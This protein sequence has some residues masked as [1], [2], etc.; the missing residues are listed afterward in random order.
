MYRENF[1]L[2][3]ITYGPLVFIP[4]LIG[5]VLF[6]SIQIHNASFKEN[7]QKI[8]K[9]L[10]K[11]EK[12]AITK[13]VQ[14]ISKFIT[15]KKSVLKQELKQKVRHR[16]YKAHTI[17][18][19]IYNEYR[20]KKTKQ[21]IKHLIKTTL[22]SLIWNNG[23]S[24][25]FA[26]DLNGTFQITPKY[27]EYLEGKNIIDF[28]DET[29]RF[30]I[31]E[32]IAIA[33]KEGEGFLWD[34]FT[35][36]NDPTKTQ[37]KQ[38]AFIKVFEPYNCYFGSSEYLDTAKKITEKKLFDA[39]K[40]IDSVGEN[41]IFLINTKGD[42]LVNKLLKN[43]I[44]TNIF[45]GEDE[46]SKKIVRSFID[47]MKEKDSESL[48]YDW[49]NPQTG[50]IEKKYSFIQ[51]VP[52]TDWIIGSGFYFSAISNKVSKAQVNTYELFYAKSQNIFYFIAIII[53]FAFLIS[54]FIS[55]KL[56][57]SFTKYEDAINKKNEQLLE[58]NN[59]LEH[60][61]K[62]RT[63]ELLALKDKF[64]ILANIDTLTNLKNRYSLLNS[65]SNELQRAHRYKTP[66]SIL[67]YDIDFFKRV[68][69]TYGHDVGDTVLVVLSQ[70]IKENLRDIDIIGRYGG[71]EFLILL[72]NTTLN[73][74]K[75]FANRIK[76]IVAAHN[77]E[78]VKDITISLGLVEVL[79][80]ETVDDVFKR[81]DTLLYYSKE[82]GRNKLSF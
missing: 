56:R 68:N 49:I 63:Q 59:T 44:G 51:K 71:E 30:V 38:I 41:Y 81:V 77:F 62:E 3:I 80:N 31:Q 54:I 27:L 73:E 76:D 42:I 78:T 40:Q 4:L 16:V 82:H 57:K 20:D 47:I 7:L 17:A 61:V 64:E 74:S 26:L 23:E 37:Y 70:I 35:K 58:L 1:F 33:K 13:R 79:Q 69:D 10:Y 9:D 18:T 39:I 24:F 15:Y 72:P 14:T 8:K 52:N 11:T 43:R 6:V 53:L 25:I 29:G 55:N 65:F 2:K 28:Q 66:L 60:Q 12:T 36:P 75:K 50:L 34:T 48:E 67:M 5:I 46:R 45:Q 22:K 32:E 21:E 19:N